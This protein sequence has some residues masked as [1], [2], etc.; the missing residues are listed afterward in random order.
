LQKPPVLGAF[1]IKEVKKINKRE[2]K[3]LQP[4]LR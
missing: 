3:K 1:A 4:K 2:G